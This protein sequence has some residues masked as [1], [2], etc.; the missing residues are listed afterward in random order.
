M[1]TYIEETYGVKG[2]YPFVRDP[3]TCVFRHRSNRKWFAVIMEIPG[4]KLGLSGGKFRVINVKCDPRLIGSFR[5]ESGIYPAYH[6]SKAHWLTVVLDGTVEAGKLKF[7]IDMS[8]ELT[9][10][11]RK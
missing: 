4:E 7:L 9:K 3:E 2:E 8:Y 6:M 1:N 11:C 10:G 5:Q